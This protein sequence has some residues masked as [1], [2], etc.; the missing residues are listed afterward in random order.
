[1][2]VVAYRLFLGYGLGLMATLLSTLSWVVL[3]IMAVELPVSPL[4][5]DAVTTMNTSWSETV[6]AIG[7]YICGF[8]GAN[9]GANQIHKLRAQLERAQSRLLQQGRSSAVGHLVTGM[10]H[11]IGNPLN[12]VHGGIEEI[13]EIVAASRDTNQGVSAD[14]L[15]EIDACSRLVTKGS[16]RID[17]IVRNLNL[18]A[19]TTQQ[20]QGVSNPLPLI[21]ATKKILDGLMVQNHVEL[22]VSVPDDLRVR[23]NPSD[24]SQVALNLMSNAVLAMESGGT[25]SLAATSLEDTVVFDVCDTGCGIA[26]D[27]RP[28]IFDPFFTTREQGEGKGLGL[29]LSL[30]IIQDAGGDLAL[31]DS[32]V[33]THMRVTLG[34]AT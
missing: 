8:V 23:I 27:I 18:L 31:M 30:Q 20:E 9:S 17:E 12:I 28:H 2:L 16:Q 14:D 13:R 24:F 34:K 1:M 15:D 26:E 19:A 5:R 4:L 11:E 29:S 3:S 25:L 21:E 7:Y 6:W 32:A 33:G 22:V 10:A